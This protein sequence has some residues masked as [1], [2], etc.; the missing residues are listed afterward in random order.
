[1]N[2]LAIPGGAPLLS[3]AMW[4]LATV[5]Q[6]VSMKIPVNKP[7]AECHNPHLVV[8]IDTWSKAADPKSESNPG[9][10]LLQTVAVTEDVSDI[11]FRY[12]TIRKVRNNFR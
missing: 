10:N 5:D 6:M 7:F 11:L 12:I 3:P 8:E 2:E 1:M 4:K 9:W